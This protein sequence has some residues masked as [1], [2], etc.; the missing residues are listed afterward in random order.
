MTKKENVVFY[1]S[2]CSLLLFFFA[3]IAMMMEGGSAYYH[4]HDQSGF[5]WFVAG[6]VIFSLYCIVCL[7]ALCL[8]EHYRRNFYSGYQTI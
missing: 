3:S 4:D 8:R 5:G 7:F 1:I 6:V 2:L